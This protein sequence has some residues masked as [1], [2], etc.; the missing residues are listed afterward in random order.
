MAYNFKL[1][2]KRSKLIAIFF[3]ILLFITIYGGIYMSIMGGASADH[4]SF[5]DNNGKKTTLTYGDALYLCL[6]TTSTT[7]YGD[8]TPKSPAAK[9]LVSVNIALFFFITMYTLVFG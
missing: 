9:A 4:W 2:R 3:V 8:I 6:M 1:T 7:G 5:N